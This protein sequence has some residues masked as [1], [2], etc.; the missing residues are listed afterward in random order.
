MQQCD[1]KKIMLE[2]EKG[3]KKRKKWWKSCNNRGKE[4][5][6]RWK[7]IKVSSN[8]NGK[9]KIYNRNKRAKENIITIASKIKNGKSYS[10]DGREED[11]S[12]REERKTKEDNGGEAMMEE[13]KMAA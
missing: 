6:K 9:K 5:N 10:N 12:G 1:R 4:R 7:T 11:G 2:E 3:K 13:N 8:K